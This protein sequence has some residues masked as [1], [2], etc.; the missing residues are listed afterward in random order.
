MSQVDQCVELGFKG[1]A[2]DNGWCVPALYDDESLF[3]VCERVAEH[4][5]PNSPGAE[6]YIRA[7]NYYLG[8]RL[9]FASSSPIRPLGLSVE[10]FA[11]LPFEDEDLRQRCLGGNVQRLLG[12]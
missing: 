1:V 10:Q 7:A 8:H 2:K 3:P 6:E 5:L 4:G 12:I 9:L 11:A